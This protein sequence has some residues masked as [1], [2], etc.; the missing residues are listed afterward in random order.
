MASGSARGSS[1][2]TDDEQV[3]GGLAAAIQEWLAPGIQLTDAKALDAADAAFVWLSANWRDF[4]RVSAPSERDES[5]VDAAARA[6][7]KLALDWGHRPWSDSWAEL[8]A[9]TMFPFAMTRTAAL[10]QA[11]ETATEQLTAI[12]ATGGE[13]PSTVE[14][15]AADLDSALHRF[16]DGSAVPSRPGGERVDWTCGGCGRRINHQL[17]HCPYDSCSAPHGKAE[18][19]G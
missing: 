11:V 13:C 14:G 17:D 8:V 18:G 2:G 9:K 6:G 16:R 10:V 7:Q 15:V 4:E 19:H 3:R 5:D 12:A 1:T